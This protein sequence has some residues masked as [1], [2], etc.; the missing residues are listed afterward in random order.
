MASYEPILLTKEPEIE[1]YEITLE[2][3]LTLLPKET[4]ERFAQVARLR[5]ALETSQLLTLL[6]E[7]LE[8]AMEQQ[9]REQEQAH[10]EAFLRILEKQLEGNSS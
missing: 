1:E 8:L 3:L 2:L 6:A 4:G 9:A 7:L 10:Q 5:G